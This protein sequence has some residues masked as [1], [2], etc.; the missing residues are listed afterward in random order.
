LVHDLCFVSG[1]SNPIVFIQNFVKASDNK[2]DELKKFNILKFVDDEHK[3]EFTEM[4]FS[5]NW[6]DVRKFFLKKYGPTYNENKNKALSLK[7]EDCYSLRDYFV[8]KYEA[9]KTFTTLN[10]FQAVEVILSTLPD[11]L[12]NLFFTKDKIDKKFDDILEFCD[13]I[14]NQVEQIYNSL[15]ENPQENLPLDEQPTRSNSLVNHDLEVF[16]SNQT[17]KTNPTPSLPVKRGPGRPRKTDKK[18]NKKSKNLNTISEES[19]D[20]ME[21]DIFASTTPLYSEDSNFTD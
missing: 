16:N 19:S 3:T 4:Y 20:T 12:S 15:N 8:R 1:E 6:D 17:I 2:T 11:H 10:D 14:E 13:M 7:F 9:F 18:N 5:N 21:T